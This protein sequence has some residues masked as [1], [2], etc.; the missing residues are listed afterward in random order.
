M[1]YDGKMRHP[2][3]SKVWKHLDELY[4]NFA[5]GPRNVRLALFID[6]FNVGA[7]THYMASNVGTVQFSSLDVHG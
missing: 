3:E 5:L 2:A 7:S 1:L 4:A 6:G